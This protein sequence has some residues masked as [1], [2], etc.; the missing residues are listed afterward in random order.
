[1]YTYIFDVT[2]E[3]YTQT[4]RCTKMQTPHI[5]MNTHMHNPPLYI[6]CNHNK[7]TIRT[8]NIHTYIPTKHPLQSKS[9]TSKKVRMAGTPTAGSKS[10]KSNFIQLPSSSGASTICMYV[11][12]YVCMYVWIDGWCLCVCGLCM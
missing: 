4:Y 11:Y 7:N 10:E 1:M 12:M 6:R 2:Y 3:P 8:G 5:H 9:A